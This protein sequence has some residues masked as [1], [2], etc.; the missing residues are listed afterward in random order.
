LPKLNRRSP[1]RYLNDVIRAYPNTIAAASARK[2]LAQVD[3]MAPAGA[4]GAV[5]PG[6]SPADGDTVPPPPA[7]PAK[8]DPSKPLPP[9][10]GDVQKYLLPLEDYRQWL[11]RQPT[12]AP[13]ETP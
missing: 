5:I 6:G 9:K 1:W 12:A 7:K 8:P 13:K 11:P 2:L 10:P 3:V 4:P